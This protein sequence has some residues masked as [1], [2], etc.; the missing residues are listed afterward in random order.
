M[1]QPGPEEAQELLQSAWLPGGREP[2]SF[3]SVVRIIQTGGGGHKLRLRKLDLST[4]RCFFTV[5]VVKHGGR[6]LVEA[7]DLHPGR[8]QPC[9][10]VLLALR[11]V[12]WGAPGAGRAKWWCP[13]PC[14]SDLASW[15]MLAASNWELLQR[16]LAGERVKIAL[17]GALC[18]R[19]LVPAFLGVWWWRGMQTVC[20]T[21][22]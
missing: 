22:L 17:R 10:L 21:S 4:R 1:A 13:P 16:G 11:L 15:P 7:V 19:L 12:G 8:H 18:P 2:G 9:N 20:A 3:F 6:L 14:V 5:R